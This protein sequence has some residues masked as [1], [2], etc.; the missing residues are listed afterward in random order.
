MPDSELWALISLLDDEDDFTRQ[1]A[2]SKVAELGAR[3]EPLL[4]EALSLFKKTVGDSHPLTAKGYGNVGETLWRLGKYAEAQPLLERAL[5]VSR[6]FFG[7]A[8]PETS[9]AYNNVAANLN[10]QGKHAEA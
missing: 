5:V 2:E 10:A 6:K 4:R 7:D 1:T 3:A 9:R 8:N